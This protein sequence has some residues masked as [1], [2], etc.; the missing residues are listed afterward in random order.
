ML[1]LPELTCPYMI[2]ILCKNANLQKLLPIDKIHV[3]SGL[4]QEGYV[5]ADVNVNN[6]LIIYYVIAELR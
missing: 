6:P 1:G 4:G 2:G 3:T 5:R